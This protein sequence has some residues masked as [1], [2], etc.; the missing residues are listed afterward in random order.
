MSVYDIPIAT[1]DGSDDGLAP[2]AGSV[3]L[4]VNVASK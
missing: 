4:V 3:T 2:L 1:I